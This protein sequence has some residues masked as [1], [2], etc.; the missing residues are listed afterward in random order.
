VSLSSQVGEDP[1]VNGSTDIDGRG[2]R[3]SL[4]FLML[5]VNL[6]FDIHN[7]VSVWVGHV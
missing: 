5:L 7:G 2:M 4:A 1:W 6:D 3:F